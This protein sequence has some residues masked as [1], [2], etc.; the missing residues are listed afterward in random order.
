VDYVAVMPESVRR[1]QPSQRAKKNPGSQSISTDSGPVLPSGDLGRYL[2]AITLSGA[3]A[4]NFPLWGMHHGA[5][6]YPLP[7]TRPSGLR[8]GDWLRHELALVEFN[9]SPLKRKDVERLI[10]ML[11][12]GPPRPDGLPYYRRD[13]CGWDPHRRKKGSRRGIARRL[14]VAVAF[15]LGNHSLTEVN[16]KVLCWRDHELASVDENGA[17][18][19][20]KPARRFWAQLGVWPWAHAPHGRLPKTWRTE[21]AFLDP[22]QAWYQRARRE[23]DQ[24]FAASARAWSEGGS[25]KRSELF[26]L[27]PEGAIRRIEPDELRQKFLEKLERRAP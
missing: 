16:A 8:P 23:V 12:P 19:L 17:R 3:P 27:P 18:E 13:L 2:G 5:D 20:R 24:E 22:L 26:K 1:T 21:V 6:L 7:L 10:E 14:A 11:A 15:D 25:L 9:G 4:L